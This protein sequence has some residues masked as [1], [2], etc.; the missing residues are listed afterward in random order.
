MLPSLC[1]NAMNSPLRLS[2]AV[3]QAAADS[4]K[5]VSAVFAKPISVTIETMTAMS[6]APVRPPS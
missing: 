2:A 5:S 1:A 4:P 6:R 3:P